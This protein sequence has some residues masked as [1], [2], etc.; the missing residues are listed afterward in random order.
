M[1][2]LIAVLALVTA[3]L[4]APAVPI[5]GVYEQSIAHPSSGYANPWEDVRLA[6]TL[7]S[8]SGQEVK[9]GGF[10]CEPDTWKFRFAPSEAGKWSWNAQMDWGWRRLGGPVIANPWS[11]SFQAV[12]SGN[13]GFVRLNPHNKMRWAFEDGF[14]Y[15]PL[16]IGDCVG[17]DKS[18][19][20]FE[21]AG[22]DGGFK[23]D[24]H[25]KGWKVSFDDYLAAYSKGGFDLFRW[26]VDNC[27]FGLYDKIDPSGNVYKQQEGIWGD[28]LCQKLRAH[29]FRIFMVFFGFKPAF[30]TDSKDPAKMDAV[31]RYV[32]YVANRYGAYVDFWELMNEFPN[33]SGQ[34]DED[35]YHQ[36]ASYLKSVDPYHH[37]VSTSG[38]RADIAEIDICGPH[39]YG[40][41]NEFDSDTTTKESFEAWKNWQKF[42]KPVI[43]GEQGNSVANWDTR[44]GLRMRLRVWTAFFTE[45]SLVFWNTSSSKDYR[46]GS[47]ANIY[48]G[49]EE[50]R[51]TKVLQDF[52]R[53]F[54]PL[55]QMVNVEPGPKTKVR[56]YALSGPAA[57][58]LYLHNYIDH[59]N[60]TSGVTVKIAPQFAGTATW[61]DPSTGKTLGSR[62]LPAGE[63]T[64]NVPKFITDVALKVVR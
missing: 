27:A 5:Y 49:P 28:Q 18:Q 63:Q 54:D 57:Y 19:K 62:K 13:H 6:V 53:G 21:N 12:A 9:I 33:G 44:S 43:F 3:N 23:D 51:Y 38:A 29:D 45:G 22:L 4:N 15:Y 40:R 2:C 20:P 26:S 32:E 1:S 42:G 61:I 17:A 11:G 34:I 14:P 48:L 31:K 16:G 60:K 30:P 37:L 50:R 47:A 55:A 35:W 39:W 52:T 64:L 46:R 10:Y 58:A 7:T 59:T 41:E 24:A 25:P 8:P 56:G 36:I